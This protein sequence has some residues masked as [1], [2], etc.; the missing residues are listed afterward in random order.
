VVLTATLTG[1]SPNPSEAAVVTPA[2][3]TASGSDFAT[4]TKVQL[5]AA[6]GTPGPNTFTAHVVGFDSGIPVD[7][8]QVTLRFVSVT[9]PN[10]APSSLSLAREE[11]VWTGQG[12]AL[13]L[14]G[15]WSVSLVTRTGGQTVQVPLVLITREDGTTQQSIPGNPT[16]STTTY[17]DGSTIQAY[18]DPGTTGT[19]QVHVTAFNAK[20]HELAVKQMTIVA[21][22]P[23]GPPQRLSFQRLSKGHGAGTVDL[24]P[25][26]W[27]FDIVASSAHATMQATYSQTVGAPT[28]PTP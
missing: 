11:D 17:P 5:T 26:D 28:S 7:A 6:P 12:S 14:A 16:I 21:V 23:D 15:T 3:I 8:D 27:T 19:N 4:T 13:S 10:V 25:G 20:G 18:A 9:Q 22:P 2:Q 1:L 24:T